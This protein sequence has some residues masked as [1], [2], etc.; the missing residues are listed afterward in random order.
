MSR[1]ICLLLYMCD[2]VLKVIAGG[3]YCGLSLYIVYIKLLDIFFQVVSSTGFPL[4]TFFVVAPQTKH[5]LSEYKSPYDTPPY[6]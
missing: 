5:H 2:L 4:T 6:H 1:P 3:L